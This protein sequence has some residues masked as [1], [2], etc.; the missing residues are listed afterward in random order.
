MGPR[1]RP[2]GQAGLFLVA[3]CFVA[4]ARQAGAHVGGDSLQASHTCIHDTLGH[5][6]TTGEVAYDA[7]PFEAGGGGGHSGAESGV[8]TTSSG[9]ASQPRRAATES[10]GHGHSRRLH[11]Y[12]SSP[13][14]A[15]YAGYQ[16]LRVALDW[17]GGSGQGA[18][19]L[20]P[21]FIPHSHDTAVSQ[22]ARCRQLR[23]PSSTSPCCQQHWPGGHT[24]C[25]CTQ[26]HSH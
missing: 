18:D 7:H 16:P 13:G 26:P 4:V 21:P 24:P 12:G 1:P 11:Q 9:P 17:Q 8:Y 6:A 5:V 2:R 10:A 22:E 19:S 14:G 3:L 15:V 23:C 20:P 25:P